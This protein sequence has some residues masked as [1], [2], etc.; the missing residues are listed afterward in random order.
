VL[1]KLGLLGS[2]PVCTDLRTRPLVEAAGVEVL[3]QTFFAR[4]NVA[5][6]GGCLGS[7]HLATWVIWRLL[8]RDAAAY[9]LAY[10]APVGERT[11]YVADVLARVGPY[12]GARHARA[13]GG[14]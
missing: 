14:G 10:V 12:V 2:L 5:S 3:D 4:G 7:P 9:A 6:V 11:A 8:G 1:A 13:A